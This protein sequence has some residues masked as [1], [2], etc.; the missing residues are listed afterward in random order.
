LQVG[1]KPVEHV[2]PLQVGVAV[3]IAT[4]VVVW[5]NQCICVSGE[6]KSSLP[7]QEGWW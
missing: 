4:T 7:M 2:W 1:M 3:L 6:R 5:N